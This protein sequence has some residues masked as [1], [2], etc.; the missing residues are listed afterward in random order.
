MPSALAMAAAPQQPQHGK[1]PIRL[2]PQQQLSRLK[3]LTGV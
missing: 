3:Q 2:G 1:Q